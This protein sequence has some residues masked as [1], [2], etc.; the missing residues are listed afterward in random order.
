MIAAIGYLQDKFSRGQMVPIV[1]S[2]EFNVSNNQILM[3]RIKR[4]PDFR[5]FIQANERQITELPEYH[6]CLEHF[7]ALLSSNLPQGSATI[8]LETRVK[9]NYILG[10]ITK[11]LEKRGSIRYEKQDFD[12]LYK[13]M[14][15]YVNSPIRSFRIIAPLQNFSIDFKE[16]SRLQFGDLG[17]QQIDSSIIDELI[18]AGIASIIKNTVD[19]PAMALE[20]IIKSNITEKLPINTVIDQLE[21]VAKAL[22]ICK[23]GFFWFD[24]VFCIQEESWE[25]SIPTTILLNQSIIG[26]KYTLS[27][28]EYRQAL[29]IWEYLSSLKSKYRF[30]EIAAERFNF[31]FS[32]KTFEDKLIDY[33]TALEALLL[34]SN[35]KSELEYRLSLRLAALLGN[36]VEERIHIRKIS[37]VGYS[38]RSCIVHGKYL[39]IALVD[40]IKYSVEDLTFE[41]EEYTRK[42]IRRFIDL[43]KEDTTQEKILDNL[44]DQVLNPLFHKST[45]A[46]DDKGE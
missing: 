7:L 19:L 9:N 40:N 14:I 8:D 29:A 37:R 6:S 3:E 4:K 5:K 22:R 15:E 24:Y 17:L 31:A 2:Y 39:K 1:Q 35:E 11:L 30:L 26:Q 43:T 21:K 13:S 34:G 23:R 18:E 44:D 10:F 45:L 41:L 42:S 12:D 46:T 38:Q 36:C 25:P 28:D 33:I 16:K 27:I 20:V 32:R